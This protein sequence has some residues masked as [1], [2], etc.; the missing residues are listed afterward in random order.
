MR[1]QTIKLLVAITAAAAMLFTGDALATERSGFNLDVLVDGSARHEYRNNG[2]IYIEALREKNYVLR[3]TNPTSRRVAVALSVDGLNTIDAKH[4]DARHARKWVIGPYDTIEISG[5]Q[6]SNRAARR[7]FFTGEPNSYGATL[8]KT[9]NLGV[10]EAVFFQEKRKPVPRWPWSRE[11]NESRDRAAPSDASAGRSAPESKAQREA[12]AD[13]DYAATGMGDKTGHRVRKVD[14][15]LE[16]H[17]S[18]KI[19]IRYE[20]RPQL[21]ELGILPEHVRPL[22]RRER[23]EGFDEYCPEPGD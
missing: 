15:D 4:T 14:I 13:D 5:W 1:N 22:H 3:L 21:V 18:A 10:I 9:E 12:A 23:A 19:R 16:D 20:F 8:G 7:F 2:T 17:P 6:V 11:E